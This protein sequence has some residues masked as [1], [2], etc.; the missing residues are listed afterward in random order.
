MLN[1]QTQRGCA[2]RCCYCTYPLIE[3]RSHRRADPEWVAEEFA[4][5]ARLGARYLFVV[6]SVF[7]SSTRHVTEICE[8]LIR[9]SVKISW[10]CFLRPQGITRDLAKLMARAGLSHAEFGSDSFS[11]PVLEAY[12][13]AFSFEDIL[14]ASQCAREA[15][16]DYCHF[17]I[18]G[19]P[20]ETAATL[21]EGFNNSRR[22]PT[23]VIMAVVGMR[24]Y[25]GTGV[26]AR[27]LA[28]G[29][30]TPSTNLLEPRYY[31][32]PALTE[33]EVFAT[34]Q[35]FSGENPAW[36]AGDPGPAYA[37]LVERLRARGTVG[38]LWSYFAMIQRLWPAGF[39]P[40]AA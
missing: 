6:D 15:G 1:V 10:G 12:E 5:A 4:R 7:N 26:H 29:S 40:T 31:L 9:K 32:S 39:A 20:E 22:L 19:G 14:N 13:K 30:L 35:R 2:L 25:P 24:I 21:Q 33:A 37:R 38:P 36:I 8:A 16:I 34:L 27:A 11:D 3:G 23:P 28:E 18:A 17:L